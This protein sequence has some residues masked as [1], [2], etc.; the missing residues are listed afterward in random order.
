MN[1]EASEREA[2][3]PSYFPDTPELLSLLHILKLLKVKLLH[4][5]VCLYPGDSKDSGGADPSD[6]STMHANF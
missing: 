5:L 4:H 3:L 1:F 2:L 6:G